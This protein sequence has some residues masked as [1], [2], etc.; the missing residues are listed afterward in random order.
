[1][2]RSP[3][4]LA[5]AL[6]LCGQARAEPAQCLGREEQRAAIA[7]GRAIALAAARRLL[8]ERLPGDVVKARLCESPDGLIY[9][10]TVL[11]HDG[12]VRRVMIDA[13]NG[14]VIGSL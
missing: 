2:S 4:V 11:S 7:E 10:L 12:K 13:T 14:A 6:V 8:R 9:M 1:M 5:M 3:L